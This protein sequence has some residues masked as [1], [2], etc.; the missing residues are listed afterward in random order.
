[1]LILLRFPSDGDTK[2]IWIAKTMRGENWFPT[3]NSTICS[4]HFT[5]DCFMGMKGRRKLLHASIPTLYLPVLVSTQFSFV[6][7]YL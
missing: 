7:M 3:S 6:K 5:P 1:M 4:K 2:G